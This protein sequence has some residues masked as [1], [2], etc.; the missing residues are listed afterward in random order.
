VGVT[1][2]SDHEATLAEIAPGSTLEVDFSDQ[3]GSIRAIVELHRHRPLSGIVAAE[4]EG[5]VLAAAGARAIGLRHNPVEAV[6]LCRRKDLFRT[7]LANT[8]LA[9]PWFEA[10]SPD[11]DPTIVRDRVP[12]PCVVKPVALA[13]SRGVIR[14]D[15]P[16][17]FEAAFHRVADIVTAA[18]HPGDERRVVLVES[19]I[20][21]VEVA[22][23][24]L[25]IDGRLRTLA[26]LD[27]PDPLVG[28]YF[29]ETLFVTPSR[30]PRSVQ[31]EIQRLTG[32]VADAIGLREGPVHAEMRVNDDGV[33]IIEMAP[34]TIGGL[35]SRIFRYRAGVSLEELVLRHALGRELDELD[36]SLPPSG[37]MMIPITGAGRLRGVGGIDAA[38]TVEGVVEIVM[39][40][41]PGQEVLPLPEGNRYLGFIFARGESAPEVERALRQSHALL[42]VQIDPT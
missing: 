12:Y 34:R 6:R 42:N 16:E 40:L 5:T 30:L 2:G 7:K 35:C 3:A 18:T 22:L 29:E 1:V 28:P 32:L 33:W 27:K 24:G 19:Y 39:S 15:G 9:A 38:E 4:D 10:F 23:E 25:L 31:Q 14:A 20:P 11:A 8:G 21:G 13:A 41:L 36:E 26:I 37:V 17:A